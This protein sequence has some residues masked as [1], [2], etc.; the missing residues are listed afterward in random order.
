MKKYE[1][2]II[3]RDQ[4]VSL[5][6]DQDMLIQHMAGDGW[7]FIQVRDRKDGGLIYYFERLVSDNE[8]FRSRLEY[9]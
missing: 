7:R 1:Y 8:S 9:T 5:V 4:K 2:V 3:E 6:V